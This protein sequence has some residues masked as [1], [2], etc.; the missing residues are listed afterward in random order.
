MYCGDE[1]GSFIGEVGSNACRFGYG[2]EDNCKYVVPSYV[3]SSSSRNDDGGG[4]DR[5]IARSSSLHPPKDD[6]V[7]ESILSMS[8]KVYQPV[9]DPNEFLHQGEIVDNW[10]NMEAAWKSGRLVKSAIPN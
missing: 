7:M 4:N 10:D 2:G 9:T 6:E 1:T 3:V 8:S 5:R